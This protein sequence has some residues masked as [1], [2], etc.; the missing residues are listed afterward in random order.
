VTKNN[1]QTSRKQPTLE[2]AEKIRHLRELTERG[3]TLIDAWSGRDILKPD[4]A[5][6][7]SMMIM[8]MEAVINQKVISDKEKEKGKKGMT[9]YEQ[10]LW[11]RL[12]MKAAFNYGRFVG[13]DE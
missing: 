1:K 3:A 9:R 5:E 7:L 10:T 8:N 11:V 13:D 2:A 12:A 6:L 4:Q